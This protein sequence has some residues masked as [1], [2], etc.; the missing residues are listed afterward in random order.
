MSTDTLIRP[1][2]DADVKFD[3]DR[4]MDADHKMTLVAALLRDV[5]CDGLLLLEPENIAW[6]TSGAVSRGLGD[7]E[8]SPAVYC[9][10]EQRWLLASNVES[11]RLF[12][13]EI[14]GLG[15]QLK[16]WPWHWGREQLLAS[17][18]GNRRIACDRPRGGPRWSP[19]RCENC[20]VPSRC[21]S[22]PANAPSV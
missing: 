1:G 14:D 13:E 7:P 21:T 22:S 5:Q 10:G 9:N 8:A 17:V 3:S 11:Q 4:R 15:F 20:D 19:T 18:S 12:D 2:S 16:E 6:L